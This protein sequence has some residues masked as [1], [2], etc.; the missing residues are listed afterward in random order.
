MCVWKT[1][2]VAMLRLSPL[3]HA[4]THTSI[5]CIR[6]SLSLASVRTVNTPLPLIW[7]R[8]ARPHVV[9]VHHR[10]HVR[11]QC[12]CSHSTLL[13]LYPSSCCYIVQQLCVESVRAL[14]APLAAQ[15][16]TD[17]AACMLGRQQQSSNALEQMISTRWIVYCHMW[18]SAICS[19]PRHVHRR[20]SFS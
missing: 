16:Q 1:R 5:H 13:T 3:L 8:A 9:S 15:R 18:W 19:H 6:S 12:R 7:M 4:C 20:Q 11:S 17:N 2:L 14:S 10:G